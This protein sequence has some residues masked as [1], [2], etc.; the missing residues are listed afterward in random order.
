MMLEYLNSFS[1]T[2]YKLIS[3]ILALSFTFSMTTG[4]YKETPAPTLEEKEVVEMME[5]TNDYVIVT[6]ATATASERTAANDL[7]KYLR[8]I[9]GQTFPIVNDSTTNAKEIVVGIT[10]REGSLYTLDRAALGNEGVFIKTVGN[11]IVITGGT[12]RGTL[13][14]VYTFLEEYLDCRWYTK[15]LI[16][17]PEKDILEIPKEIDYTFVPSLEYRETDWISPRDKQWSYANKV[18]GLVYSPIGGADTGGGVGY[19]G[20]FAHTMQT[21]FNPTLMASN[22][23]IW[24]IGEETGKPTEEHPCLSQPK[25]KQIML[26]WVFAQLNANPT[27]QIVSVTHPDNQNYCICDACKAVYAEEGSTSGM[28]I[29]F[30]NDIADAVKAKYPTRDVSVDTFAYQYTRKVPSKTVPRDNVI[31]RLCSIECCFVHALDDERCERNA[32][33]VK[34]L[35]N[36]KEICKHLY[37]WDYTTNYSNYNGPFN[38]WAVMQ[39]NMKTFVENNVV[40]IYEEGNYTAWEANGE[41]ANLRSYIL[42]KLMWDADADVNRIMIEFCNAYYGDASPYILKYL[43]LVT[44]RSGQNHSVKQSLEHMGIFENVANEGVMNLS[45]NDISYIDT[46]WADAKKVETLSEEQLKNVRLSEISW[47]VWKSTKGTREF[48]FMTVYASNEQLYKD[49]KELGITRISEG[50]EGLLAEKPYFL[51]P[52]GRWSTGRVPDFPPGWYY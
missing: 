43:T 9:C 13:Y 21:V 5:I 2:V 7:Q 37:I 52:P 27:R 4:I 28:M 6:N 30:V 36:W 50:A 40:G 41:F 45:Q 38:N 31:V 29:R 35:K 42:A 39:P 1:L 8:Q 19:A 20:S 23:D 44:S 10:N 49:M 15:D 3:A 32:D 33:F 11:D 26:D 51:D 47:R 25:T 14:A 17:I 48:G 34:D 12:L 18:N 16:V 22:T 46:I 24:A